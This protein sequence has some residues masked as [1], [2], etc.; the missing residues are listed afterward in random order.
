M[1]IGEKTHVTLT[2]E[3]RTDNKNNEAIETVTEQTPLQF[4][5]GIGKMIPM[6]EKKLLNLKADDN[7]DFELTP[8]E[9]YGEYSDKMIAN[10]PMDIF[11][12]DGKINEELVKIDN[13]IPMHMKDGRVLNGKILS[14]DN[15]SVKMDFNHPLAGKNLFFS[16]KIL[17][18][19]EATEEELEDNHECT[20][21]GKD[22]CDC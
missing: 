6:F 5:F 12:V 4:V 20:G 15:E 21:C 10:V 3:L 13:V 18:I 7:F 17:N 2:Y 16:G 1:T 14:F 19:R 22:S 11:M 8:E 9:S